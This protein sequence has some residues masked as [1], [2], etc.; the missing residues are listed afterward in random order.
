MPRITALTAAQTALLTKYS[1]VLVKDAPEA[2]RKDLRKARKLRRKLRMERKAELAAAAPK[3]P[4][5]A[6]PAARPSDAHVAAHKATGGKVTKVPK[7]KRTLSRD[8]LKAALTGETVEQVQA[9][10]ELSHTADDHVPF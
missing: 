9:E 2:V 4:A 3:A 10:R 5:K 6:K 7:G 8:E 1:L